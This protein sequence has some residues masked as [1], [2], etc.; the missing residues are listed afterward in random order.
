M[1]MRSDESPLAF[2]FWPSFADSMLGLVL[3]VVLLFVV[4]VSSLGKQENRADKFA[5][6]ADSLRVVAQS[7]QSEVRDLEGQV[8][9]QREKI[10]EQTVEI[11]QIRNRQDRIRKEIARIYERVRK[12]D[13]SPARS[14]SS[15]ESLKYV[16]YGSSGQRVIDIYYDLQ[17]QRLTFNGNVLFRTN[18]YSLSEEGRELLE[19]VGSAINDEIDSIERIQIEGHTDARPTAQ[20]QNGNLELGAL[21]AISVYKFFEKSPKVEINPEKHTMSIT[22]F[23]PHRPVASNETAEERSRNRRIEL[24]LFF[25]R[26]S[27]A[28]SV[29][30]SA[31]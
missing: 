15:S 25:G 14:R 11:T 12:V 13:V 7:L 20:Y 1:T 31:G 26:G 5:S 21:R 24:L 18:E 27:D 8:R 2:N 29:D 6:R 3:V 19:V 17:L 10:R 9:L 23:G 30:V 4:A 16:V 22:S 28:D